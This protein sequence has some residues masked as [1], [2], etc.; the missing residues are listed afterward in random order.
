MQVHH[1]YFFK[2]CTACFLEY[3][4]VIQYANIFN[5]KNVLL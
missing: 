2:F 1:Q 5:I 4:A 3:A